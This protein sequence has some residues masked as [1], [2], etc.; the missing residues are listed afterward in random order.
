V[1]QRRTIGISERCQ[2]IARGRRREA[3]DDPGSSP[4]GVRISGR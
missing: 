1:Q 4:H 3:A 2:P